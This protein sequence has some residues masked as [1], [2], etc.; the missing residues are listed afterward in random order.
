MIIESDVMIPMC[1]GIQIALKI[2]R[3][4]KTEKYPAL[5]AASP[6]QYDTDQLP[7]LPLFLWRETEPIEWYVDKGYAFVRMDVRG[8]G[9]SGGSYG[10]L[11]KN[12]QNDYCEVIEWIASQVWCN[13]KIG[14]Y[15]QS[16]YAMAQWLMGTLNPPGL[17][18]IAPYDGLV[19]PYRDQAYHGGVYSPF[20]A[21]WYTGVRANNALRPG[22]SEL[23]N[24][25][26][27]DLHKELLIH[28][29]YDEWWEER[30]AYEN[31]SNITIPTLSIGH[32]GKMGLHLRG[33]ILGYEQI[34]GPKKLIITGASNT[35]E[36]HAMFDKIEFH[37]QELLPFYDYYL[38]GKDNAYTSR[39]NVRL[40]TYGNECYQEYDQW[41]P[42]SSPKHY[43]LCSVRSGSVNSINDGSLVDDLKAEGDSYTNFS[44]P[45][46]EWV[47]GV[48]SRNERGLDPVGKI[49]TFT[50]EILDRDIEVIGPITLELY[51][52]SDQSDTDFIVKLSD[53]FAGQ[54]V[55][56][57]KPLSQP[58]YKIV[59]KGWLRASHRYLDEAKTT[60]LRPIYTH[61]NV[62]PLTLNQIYK[63]LIEIQ[64][65][66][67]CFK[68]GNR[69]RLEIANGDSSM[70]DGSF[71]HQYLWWKQGT[72]TYYH[73]EAHPSRLIL[74]LV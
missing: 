67:Y 45:D 63:F 16:Y 31:L 70:T 62:E 21:N 11:D 30:S 41:P 5:L 20:P 60:D 61:K 33:N 28:N 53:Q 56:N 22:T 55:A 49:I 66:A 52:S 18:C 65:V 23:G 4:D 48:V 69:I 9:K 40:W 71:A 19:D 25:M 32:W 73:S 58:R 24:L 64:P 7:A 50:S 39:K 72:D 1:D 15:G 46:L 14:G 44:Y 47:N 6:Y 54:D 57:A 8:S 12:E 36:A 35:I 37:E 42:L 26:D 68:K 38:K 13:G 2:Y 59:S 51:A 74:P 43:Y 3:P 10:Y 27:F 29:T 17:S 34:R